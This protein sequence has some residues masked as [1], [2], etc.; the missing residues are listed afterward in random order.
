MSNKI[1]IFDLSNSS[2][3]SLTSTKFKREG[4]LFPYVCKITDASI[5]FIGDNSKFEK[6]KK[7]LFNSLSI[8]LPEKQS[9]EFKR[10]LDE[11]KRRT[12]HTM[13]MMVRSSSKWNWTHARRS[14]ITTRTHQDRSTEGVLYW[15]SR[16]QGLN[17]RHRGN[18]GKQRIQGQER[19]YNFVHNSHSNSNQDH[20]Y[21]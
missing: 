13:N 20:E 9:E 10:I 18:W 17:D 5:L 16:I 19:Q 21:E 11:T 2:G 8:I 1:Q 12:Y 7:I 6:A 15:S 14:W 4:S 3:I